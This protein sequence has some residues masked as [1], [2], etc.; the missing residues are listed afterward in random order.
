M[1]NKNSQVSSNKNRI[2]RKVNEINIKIS[3]NTQIKAS[4]MINIRETNEFI[5]LSNQ[6]DH[7]FE[8]IIKNQTRKNV[9]KAN[10]ENH[11]LILKTM[12]KKIIKKFID[13]LF[14]KKPTKTLIST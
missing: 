1:K 7:L 6:F 12:F 14:K 2:K 10:K 5:F 4:I 8:K 3:L 9:E 13:S 11:S